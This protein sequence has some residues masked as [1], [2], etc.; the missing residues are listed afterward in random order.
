[1]WFCIDYRR[2]NAITIKDAFPLP[3][4]DEIFDQLSDAMYY[5]KFDFKY[6][7]LQV[8]LSKEDCPKTAFSIRDNQYQFIV[9]PQGITNRF[10]TF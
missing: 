7:Y 5:T 10:A 3:R 2:L 6:G 8:P 4:F 9:L 1:M